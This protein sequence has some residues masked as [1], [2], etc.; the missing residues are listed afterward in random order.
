MV[1]LGAVTVRGAGFTL[2]SVSM[3]AVDTL[4]PVGVNS[5]F[6]VWTPAGSTV[7]A[8]GLYVKVPDSPEMASS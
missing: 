7:P 5:A 4:A 2:I 6:R 3:V 8:D 1:G